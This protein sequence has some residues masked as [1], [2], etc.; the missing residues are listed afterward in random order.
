MSIQQR[1]RDGVTIV[2][3]SSDFTVGRQRPRALDLQGCPVDDLSETLLDLLNGGQRNIILDMSVVTFVDSAGLGE[4]VAC[5][6]R[7]VERG[8]DIR[9]LQPRKKVR[10]LLVMTLLTQIF[11]IYADEEEAVRSFR[12]APRVAP[13]SRRPA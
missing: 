11:Q 7:A 9:L 13:S 5:K 6:K 1:T 12:D 4:L 10:E 2:A 8:G 3:L